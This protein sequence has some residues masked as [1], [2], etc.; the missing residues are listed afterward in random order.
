MN[1][2]KNNLKT[3]QHKPK[4]KNRFLVKF[5]EKFKINPFAIK[6]CN[7]PKFINDEWKNIKIEFISSTEPS[8]SQSLF[9]I[10]KFIK[11]NNTNKNKKIFDIVIEELD[12]SGAI[13]EQWFVSVEKVLI[14]NF[15]DLDNNKIREPF[16][17]IKPI[18]CVLNF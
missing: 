1:N 4:I 6:K 17:L 13:L 7:K 5:P 10:V 11:E 9:K 8:I 12:P 14:I 16:I 2:N 15:G 18:N 3:K